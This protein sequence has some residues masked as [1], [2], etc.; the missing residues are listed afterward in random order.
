MADIQNINRRA[1]SVLGS[2]FPGYLS[3][4]IKTFQGAVRYNAG[5]NT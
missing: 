3:K 1:R 5:K 4:N 2:L